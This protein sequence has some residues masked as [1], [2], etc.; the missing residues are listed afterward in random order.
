MCA[1]ICNKCKSVNQQAKEKLEEA[2]ALLEN[3]TLSNIQAAITKIKQAK[4]VL[5]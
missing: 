4:D 3:T 5:E 1:G 2:I